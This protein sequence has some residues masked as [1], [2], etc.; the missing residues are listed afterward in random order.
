[1][2]DLASQR[3]Y[4]AKSD[5]IDAITVATARPVAVAGCGATAKWQLLDV[6]RGAD[7]DTYQVLLAESANGETQDILSTDSGATAYVAALPELGEVHG[8]L[9]TGAATPLGAEQSNTNLVVG[10]TI[11]KVF[12]HLEDGLNPDVELLTRIGDCPH[13][14]AVNAYVTRGEQTLAMQ[15]EFIRGGIDGFVLT[16]GGSAEGTLPEAEVAAQAE[17]L[18]RAMRTVHEAL[19]HAFGVQ[20]RPTRSIADTLT[21]NLDAY[22]RRAP[23]LADFAP[24]IRAL[25]AELGRTESTVPVQRIHG[26]LHL[27]QTLKT[28]KRWYLID[29]EGEP[30]RPLAQRRRPDHRLRDVAGMVRSYG[31]ARAVGGFDVEWERGGVEKLLAGYGAERDA[32]LAAYIVDKAAY[33]VIYEANNRPD[34]VDI[35]L[36]AIRD[37]V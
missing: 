32:L 18:G 26:D 2:F 24:R 13:V 28:P 30:A 22:V 27:G 33:E 12:R 15:Q 19:A 16:T 17:S 35:P 7:S 37:L 10:N 3:F 36:D 20:E 25:Y 4:G 9:I 21:A 23:L 14:A 5:T 31:Y 6:T 29:F 11:V 8:D 1:M 34:W